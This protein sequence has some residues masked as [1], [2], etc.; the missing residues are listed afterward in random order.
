MKPDRKVGLGSAIGIPLG[1]LTA[2]GIGL[3]GVE[4][5]P[6]VAAALGATITGL[7]TYLVPNK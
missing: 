3:A 1:I 4:V 2:W 5:P 7:M 6:E